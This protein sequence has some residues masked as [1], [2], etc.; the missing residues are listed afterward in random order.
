VTCPECDGIGYV[1][2]GSLGA[3]KCWKCNDGVP[4]EAHARRSDPPTSQQA[5]EQVRGERAARLERAYLRGLSR[6]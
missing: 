3:Q 4:P 5:A 2:S 6:L 1:K